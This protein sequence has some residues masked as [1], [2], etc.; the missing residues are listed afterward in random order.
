MK[1]TNIIRFVKERNVKCCE[2]HKAGCKGRA[3]SVGEAID[4]TCSE[5]NHPPDQA[6][7][8]AE[9]LVSSMRK[10][11][12]EETVSIHRIY[13]DALQ[14][15]S[16]DVTHES[17]TAK[18]H[19]MSFLTFKKKKLISWQKEIDSFVVVFIACPF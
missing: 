12:R 11:A 3:T 7:N 13:D 8:K 9:K 19:C 5:Q 17:V 4:V 10:W 15:I 2:F 18:L 16:Q 1:A 6:S 14:E